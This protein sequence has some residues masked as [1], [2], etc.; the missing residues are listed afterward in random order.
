MNTKLSTFLSN[1]YT[2]FTGSRGSDGVN[3]VVISE[4][5]PSNPTNG[6]LWYKPSD[7]LLYMWSASI[8]KFVQV[9]Q[10]IVYPS[11]N[12]ENSYTQPGTYS[13]TC[14]AGVNWVHVVCVGGGGGG[15]QSTA[16]GSGGGGGG[17]AWKNDIAVTPGST[18]TVVVGAGTP[19]VT[20]TSTRTTAGDSYFINS[21]TVIAYGGVSGLSGGSATGGSGG[22]YFP[23]GGSGGN[24]GNVNGNDTSG[25]VRIV[26]GK[27]IGRAHV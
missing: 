6:Q 20:S 3:S 16:G 24:G 13:W 4:T 19:V 23:Y 25:G 8:W 2:G 9:S 1:E 18:Y 12:G 27:Q 14:P 15:G 10:T 11:T 5:A 7:D 26:T 17:L 22:G 21:S